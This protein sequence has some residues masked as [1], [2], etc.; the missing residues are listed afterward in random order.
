MFLCE[1]WSSELFHEPKRRIPYYVVF[2]LL[3][4]L[5]NSLAPYSKSAYN[6]TNSLGRYNR[7]NSNNFRGVEV[8]YCSS[9]FEFAV[10]TGLE[11]YMR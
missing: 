9:L 11:V 6:Q 3:R 4:Q 1:L 5:S 10:A 7:P 8:V 2:R